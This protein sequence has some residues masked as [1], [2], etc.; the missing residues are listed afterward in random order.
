M[1][2]TGH[3]AIGFAAKRWDSKIPVIWYLLGANIIDI[4][5]LVLSVLGIESFGNNHWTHSLLMAII[6]ANL[7]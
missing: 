5:Y 3:L 7:G 1:S 2:P 4:V 6:Y